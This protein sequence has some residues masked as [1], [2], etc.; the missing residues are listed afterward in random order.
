MLCECFS[1][2]TC[3]IIFLDVCNPFILYCT[4]L[5][6]FNPPPFTRQGVVICHYLVEL[7]DARDVSLLVSV[8]QPISTILVDIQKQTFE[9]LQECRFSPNNIHALRI[10]KPCI[11]PVF[12]KVNQAIGC[13]PLKHLYNIYKA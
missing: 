11:L 10:S 12:C 3:Q 6:L 1:I 8:C 7:E 5:L 4:L 9:L 13:K 2:C